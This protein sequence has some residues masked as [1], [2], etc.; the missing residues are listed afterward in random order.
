MSPCIRSKWTT[1]LRRMASH[2]HSHSNSHEMHEHHTMT[3]LHG[4]MK[5]DHSSGGHGETSGHTVRT[6]WKEDKLG[7]EKLKWKHIQFFK[8]IL[9]KWTAFVKWYYLEGFNIKLS[10]SRKL[11]TD[12]HA[13]TSDRNS[14]QLMYKPKYYKN[15]TWS[16]SVPGHDLG[17]ILCGSLAQFPLNELSAWITAIHNDMKL[18]HLQYGTN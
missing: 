10:Y 4:N 11:D 13:N 6:K 7:Q 16:K 14:S 12:L 15:H 1:P 8:C 17:L 9:M 3:T 5:N 2:G 18:K